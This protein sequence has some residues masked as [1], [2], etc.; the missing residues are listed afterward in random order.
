MKERDHHRPP[1][2]TETLPNG[3]KVELAFEAATAPERRS[4]YECKCLGHMPPPTPD[5]LL[6]KGCKLFA[7][8]ERLRDIQAVVNEQASDESLWG[9]S[10]DGTTPLPEA[11]LQQELR[12]LH[13]VCENG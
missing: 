6:C 12:R 10:L 9:T 4:P 5:F 11:H 8:E 13:R 3:D 2:P 7:A 1:Y